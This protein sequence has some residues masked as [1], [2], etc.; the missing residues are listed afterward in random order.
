M[1]HVLLFVSITARIVVG[2]VF[3]AAGWAKLRTEK[4]AFL[5]AV[6]AYDL[7][8]R[9]FAPAFAASLPLLEVVIGLMLV[10]GLLVQFV[11]WIGIALLVVV[12]GAVVL[13]LIQK[14]GISCGC[15]GPKEKVTPIRW[16]IVTRNALLMLMLSVV[17]LKGVPFFALD[18]IL[19]NHL[20]NTGHWLL[21]LALAGFIGI[22][23]R[24]SSQFLTFR[25]SRVE[26]ISQ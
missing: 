5:R 1:G 14:K 7:L 23:A 16:S 12:T 13:A 3:I 9:F 18:S 10:F 21:G 6:L 15:F 4:S 26:A 19:Q 8:P 24:L 22:L 20:G 2:L 17:L 25:S 11:T